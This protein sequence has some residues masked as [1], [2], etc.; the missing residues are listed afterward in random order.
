[1]SDC[2]FHLCC[3]IH[4]ELAAI[5]GLRAFSYTLQINYLVYGHDKWATDVWKFMCDSMTQPCGWERISNHKTLHDLVNDTVDYVETQT[6]I[7]WKPIVMICYAPP[8]IWQNPIKG[9]D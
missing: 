5:L 1:M 2:M 3:K 6:T 7:W 9:H 4:V 8:N